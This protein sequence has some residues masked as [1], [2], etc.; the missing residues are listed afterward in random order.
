VIDALAAAALCGLP[1]DR[2]TDGEPWERELWFTVT[3]RALDLHTRLMRNHAIDT[4]NALGKVLG[5]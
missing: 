2:I 5:G 4:A 1:T 3:R